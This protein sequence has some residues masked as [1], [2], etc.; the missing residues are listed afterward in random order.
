MRK[1]F[2][3]LGWRQQGVSM[4]VALVTLTILLL[5]SVALVRSIDSG[6]LIVG[7]LAFKQD[8]TVVSS[9]AAEQAMA[10]LEANVDGTT[11]DED[12]P[13]AGYY[14]SSLDKLDPTGANTSAANPMAL[15]DWK[16]DSCADTP[17]GHYT[18][19]D[20]LPFTGQSVNGNQIQWVITRLCDSVGTPSAANLCARPVAVDTA[21][22]GDRGNLQAG[23]RISASVAGPYFRVIVKTT[24]P[25]HTVSYTETM[26]HF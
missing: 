11:L 19:C 12:L 16:L 1:D 14:A 5:A 23:G 13:E 2:Q 6:T 25:R 21:S 24:G 4:L 9:I 7:N 22:A 26:L 20:T 15:I 18:N 17:S 10:W 3:R 8:T